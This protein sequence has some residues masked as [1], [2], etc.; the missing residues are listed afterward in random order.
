MTIFEDYK[1]YIN[2]FK[3]AKEILIKISNALFILSKSPVFNNRL[4]VGGIYHK[5]YYDYICGGF[6]DENNMVFSQNNATVSEFLYNLKQNMCNY[7]IYFSEDINGFFLKIFSGNMFALDYNQQNFIESYLNKNEKI[8][9]KIITK[10]KLKNFYEENY[11]KKMK[12]KNLEIYCKNKHLNNQLEKFNLSNKSDFKVIIEN[13]LNYKILNK[14]NSE[15]L[16]DN[17]FINF[18][19]QILNDDEIIKVINLTNQKK[20]VNSKFLLYNELTNNFDIFKTLN[21]ISWRIAND[22]N[23]SKLV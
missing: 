9:K 7:G 3:S 11:L 12:F 10:E 4:G 17:L 23:Y 5:N 2:K 18:K 8:F 15:I 16:K 21:Y 6:C 1:I 14:K 13:D 22:K 19:K 20:V